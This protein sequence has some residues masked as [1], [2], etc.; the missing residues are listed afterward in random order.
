MNKRNEFNLSTL[1]LLVNNGSNFKPPTWLRHPGYSSSSP[2]K[3]TALNNR[4]CSRWHPGWC[5]FPSNISHR[6][7][8]ALVCA[9]HLHQPFSLKSINPNMVGSQSW[10]VPQPARRTLG[11]FF[12]SPCEPTVH[13]CLSAYMFVCVHWNL[14][15][16]RC[17]DSQPLITPTPPSPRTMRLCIYKSLWPC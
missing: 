15:M 1:S 17:F 7:S 9:L 2:L 11:C 6:Q 14:C 16:R 8:R 3:D 12:P 4:S 5:L 13:I 10:N